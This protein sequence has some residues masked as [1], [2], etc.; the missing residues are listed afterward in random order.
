MGVIDNTDVN[1]Y[2]QRLFGLNL[3][4]LT[5]RYFLAAQEAF[6]GIGA[7]V[8][9]DTS[10]AANPV[11]RVRK[12][13]KSLIAPAHKNTVWLNG[14]LLVMPTVTVYN[15]QRFFVSREMVELLEK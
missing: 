9:V 13:R 5:S 6:E 8:V 11:L 10:R 1:R 3:D 4:E 12:G 7:R 14:R 15:G 2:M